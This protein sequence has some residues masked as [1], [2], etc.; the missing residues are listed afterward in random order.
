MSARGQ[1]GQP[2]VIRLNEKLG[3]SAFV[4]QVRFTG[5]SPMEFCDGLCDRDHRVALSK[6]LEHSGVDEVGPKQVEWY[7]LLPWFWA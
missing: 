7:F 6:Q 1:G 5:K 3:V 4:W 2:L